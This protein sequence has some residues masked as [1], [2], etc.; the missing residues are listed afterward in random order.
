MN[1]AS[2]NLT[3]DEYFS[4]PGVS[5]SSLKLF[6]E[7]PSKYQSVYIDGMPDRKKSAAFEF[8]TL[9]HELAYHNFDMSIFKSRPEHFGKQTLPLHYAGKNWITP[10]DSVLLN[11]A[12]RG[13]A[14]LDWKSSV[15]EDGYSV[16][17]ADWDL[18]LLK[19]LHDWEKAAEGKTIVDRATYAK[20]EVM[21][22]GMVMNPF[23]QPLLKTHKDMREVS[24]FWE[25]SSTGLECKA[26]IDLMTSGLILDWKTSIN[27]CN[28]RALRRDI[29]NYKY[30]WQAAWYTLA[31]EKLTGL[32]PNFV[33]CFVDKNGYGFEL[34]DASLWMEVGDRE[35][36]QALERLSEFDFE[37]NHT[38]GP[39][40]L[41]PPDYLTES[42]SDDT[43]E[44]FT[45]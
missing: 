45:L 21:A 35:V 14:Y 27:A 8:G 2:L 11:K 20:L 41:A 13:K 31:V 5:Q 28:T 38:R 36:R 10:P 22:G 30:Y 37:S 15:E 23:L 1:A 18:E 19:N 16:A 40:Q 26:K 12:R 34:V 25:D 9:F 24:I 7:N 43:I 6:S 4:K 44:E 39:I 3:D 29:A 42:V 32:R 33:F 17:P